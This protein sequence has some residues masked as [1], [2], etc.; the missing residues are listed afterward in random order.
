MN[1]APK[2]RN[3][4]GIIPLTG[5]NNSFDFPGRTV[6]AEPRR[7]G[8][9]RRK[10]GVAF[11]LSPSFTKL[12]NATRLAD[13]V[14]P[15]TVALSVNEHIFGSSC[16]VALVLSYITRRSW[17]SHKRYMSA[18]GTSLCTLLKMYLLK[19]RNEGYSILLMGD[20][21]GCTGT[22]GAVEQLSFSARHCAACD[23][24]MHCGRHHR[25]R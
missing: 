6:F 12:S 19:L 22:C 3:V 17:K 23:E 5:W 16:K 20:L 24:G 21:N 14:P 11:L 25:L 1:K 2:G 18:T 10:G 8:G 15:E 13:D 4:A 7:I 9:R